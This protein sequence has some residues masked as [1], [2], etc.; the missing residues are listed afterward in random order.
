MPLKS[1]GSTHSLRSIVSTSV[2]GVE[3]GGAGSCTVGVGLVLM[4]ATSQLRR[5]HG[6]LP[7]PEGIRCCGLQ[8]GCSVAERVV[9]HGWS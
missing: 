8:R 6:A 1:A 5:L 9:R 7:F 2:E 3:R 4:T